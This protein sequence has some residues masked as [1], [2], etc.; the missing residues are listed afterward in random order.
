MA[1]LFS[2]V[3][4]LTGQQLHRKVPPVSMQKATETAETIVRSCGSKPARID[5]LRA[6]SSSYLCRVCP[7]DL[8]FL[9]MPLVGSDT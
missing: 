8:K 1:I 3:S 9:A 6:A 2:I 7:G 4:A 5:Y